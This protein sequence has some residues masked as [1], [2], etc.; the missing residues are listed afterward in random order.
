MKNIIK[1]KNKEISKLEAEKSDLGKVTKMKE[2]EVNDKVKSIL[3]HQ[4]SMKALK[5]EVK[6]LKNDK[7]ALNK[8]I[9]QLEKDDKSGKHK[10]LMI[11]TKIFH[12]IYL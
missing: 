8:K 7:N 5:E 3:A 2:K 4:N 9:K 1:N 10:L 6:K 12:L 11:P